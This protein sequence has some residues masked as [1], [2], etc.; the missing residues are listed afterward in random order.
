MNQITLIG[1][2]NDQYTYFKNELSKALTLMDEPYHLTEVNALDAIVESELESI[3]A[4]FINGK[5]VFVV[6]GYVPDVN[7]ILQSLKK[8]VAPITAL[9]SILIP[10]DFS[11]ISKNAFIYGQNMAHHYGQAIHVI[12]V[13]PSLST[14]LGFADPIG[15][16]TKNLRKTVEQNIISNNLKISTDIVKGNVVNG[17]INSAQ[18]RDTDFIVM[19]TTGKTNNTFLGSISRKIS[20]NK[21]YPTFLIP[22]N[23]LFTPFSKI[24]FAGHLN[25]QNQK[26]AEKLSESKLFS[27]AMINIV[28]IKVQ[29]D[30]KF[31]EISNKKTKNYSKILIQ[32]NDVVSGLT[33]FIKKIDADLLIMYKPS[34]PFWQNI[35]HKSTTK[36]I[37]NEIK[38]PL[39]LLH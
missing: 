36:K 35:F 15:I 26:L 38:I 11:E 10:I 7:E 20:L 14:K 5:L 21:K 9:N 19:G 33:T 6:N 28:E 32:D 39:L 27:Q 1:I 30:V 2:K 31:K 23:Y 37:H 4:L 8:F 18:K 24:V 29:Q 3:P 17:I 22:E 13:T 34:K 16:K 12:H 25:T